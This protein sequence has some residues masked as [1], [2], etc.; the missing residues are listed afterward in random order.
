MATLFS[1][2]EIAILSLWAILGASPAALRAQEPVTPLVITTPTPVVAPTPWPTPTPASEVGIYAHGSSA[3]TYTVKAGDTLLTVALEVGIDLEDAYCMVRPDFTW[4]EPLVI[5]DALSV[6]SPGT[7]CHE[8]TEGE[9]LDSI[10]AQYGL[11]HQAVVAEAWNGLPADGG[12][13]V[14][15]VPGQHLRIPPIGS[16]VAVGNEHGRMEIPDGVAE[17]EM[18][19]V[20]PLLLNQR[21]DADV[22]TIMAVGKA[23]A[24][25]EAP[26]V[27]SPRVVSMAP[28]PADWPY[29]SGRFGWP[30]AGWLTQGYRDNHRAIDVAAPAGTVV[31]AADRGVVIRAGW[32]NLGYGNFVIIDHNIDYITLYAHMSQVLVEEGDVLAAGQPIGRVGSTGNSTGPHLHFEIRD[33]GRR[34]D[35]L[36]YLLR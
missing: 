5:G 34:I 32:N 24:G 25:G 15:L 8:T 10:A 23:F 3:T 19:G 21:V 7:I 28:V 27:G 1:A 30:L 26:A 2:T 29:G 16:A 13:T 36:Q 11:P 33:F 31:T 12:T 22:S 14:L 9:T 17:S 6:P 18:T 4:A 35:P 20:L